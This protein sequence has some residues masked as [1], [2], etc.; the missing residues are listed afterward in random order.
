MS[1]KKAI[2]YCR[3]SSQRQVDEGHG[4]ESQE[5]S[6]RNYA[7][8]KG[9]IVDKA[10]HEGA[11]SGGDFDRPEMNKLLEY[12]TI[13]NGEFVV[14]FDD[15]S[16]LARDVNVHRLLVRAIQNTGAEI[17]C[18][19]T[20]VGSNAPSDILVETMIA[21]TK[22]YERLNNRMQVIAR[23]RARLEMGYWPF[24]HP[25]GYSYKKTPIHG[26]LL[27]RD[28]PNASIIKEA[29]EG[30][31][32][33]RF[34]TQEDVRYFL[35]AKKY[36]A[37]N[38]STKPHAETVKRMLTKSL[39]A[40]I[41]EYKKWGVEAVDGHHEP[42]IT[43]EVYFKI[44]DKLSGKVKRYEGGKGADFPLRGFVQC[45]ECSEY[46]TA[47]WSTGRNKKHPY[48]RCKNKDCS[49]GNKSIK[50]KSIES[51]FLELLKGAEIQT[52]LIDLLKAI[53]K[54]LFNERIKE[55]R[56]DKKAAEK[57]MLE[58]DKDI[59][60][61]VDRLSTA[62]SNNVA[63]A[64]ERSID[65]KEQYKNILQRKHLVT[66]ESEINFETAINGVLDFVGNPYSAWKS[67]DLLQKSRIQRLV[68]IRPLKYSKSKG[69]GTAE[70]SLPFS[71]SGISNVSKSSV[72]EMADIQQLL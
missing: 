27:H 63:N 45:A 71:I 70:M 20:I 13:N 17:D 66:N 55:S 46:I 57:E 30:F 67:G 47:S 36:K 49:C 10:F 1:I 56:L 43:K 41:V 39:Y 33:N 72:V 38:K 7:N 31:A 59:S 51:D 11:I 52:P 65:E 25:P 23:Q 44:Q 8:S 18:I 40:G 5:K 34:V 42:L 37:T 61:L 69:F 15:I 64:I 21:A 4:L 14:I 50:R 58:L 12:L 26:K 29:L 28:E 32:N 9:Y 19:G 22:E 16:R 54:E 53:A 2:I 60:S 24:C 35:E 3:V 48:Y 62:S 6:C 68:F